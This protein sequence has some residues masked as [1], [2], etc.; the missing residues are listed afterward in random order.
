M[1][2]IDILI[3]TAVIIVAIAILLMAALMAWVAIRI[4]RE[5]KHDKEDHQS[6]D[7]IR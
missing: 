6:D 1:E 7:Q 2:A 5:R 3:W 4:T